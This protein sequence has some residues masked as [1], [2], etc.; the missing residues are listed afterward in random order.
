M[1]NDWA[2]LVALFLQFA[3]LSL[4]AVGGASTAV[5]EM[6]RQTVEIAGW[7]TDRQFSELFAMAQRRRGPM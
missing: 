2:T 7:L 6:H 3:T 4:F 5:P 1:K